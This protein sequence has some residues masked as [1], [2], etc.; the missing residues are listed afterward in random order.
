MLSGTATRAIGHGAARIPGLRR[1]PV[2]K[3]LAIAEIALLARTHATRLDRD[4][5]RRLVDLVRAARGRPSTLSEA[6]REELA[7]LVAK[8]EPRR[9]VGLAADKLSPV[10]LPGRLVHGRQR[11]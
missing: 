8:T 7:R 3:L 11:G 10:P 1:I 5:R 6:E 2:F 9:F 4:E